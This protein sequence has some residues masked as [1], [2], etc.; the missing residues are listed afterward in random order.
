MKKLP[1]KPALPDNKVH[2]VLIS[3]EYPE[4]SQNLIDRFGIEIIDVKRDNKLSSDIDTHADC[5]FLQVNENCIIIDKSLKSPI[6]NYLTNKNLIDEIQI[7]STENKVASPYPGDVKLNVTVVN[8]KIICNT[9]YI[10]SSLR[11]FANDHS[12]DLIHVNQGYAACSV[13]LI[14]DNAL[15]TDDESIYKATVN[16]GFDCLLISKGSVRLIGREYGFIG[17]TCGM[18]DNNLIVFTGKLDTHTDCLLIKEFLNKYCVSY[19]ELT[20]GPL[21]DI[22]GIIPLLQ[23]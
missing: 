2:S 16:N 14:N 9:K 20:D 18:I 17:G 10:D 7:I 8:N 11:K 12:F 3:A 4:I 1:S 6:V 13:V 22:G 21:I 23:S 15:I 5:R 19:I